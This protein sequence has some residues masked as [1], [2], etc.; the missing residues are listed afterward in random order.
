MFFLK[1]YYYVRQRDKCHEWKCQPEKFMSPELERHE[2]ILGS[3][4]LMVVSSMSG[5]ISWYAANDG[6]YLKLYYRLDE[7]GY[8]WLFLQAPIVFM[9]Q[10]S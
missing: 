5:L 7:Y 9:Y 6:R 8:I 10:V 2:I 4:S 3:M 1:W